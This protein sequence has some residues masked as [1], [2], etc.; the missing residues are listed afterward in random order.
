MKRLLFLVLFVN[1]IF[2]ALAASDDK[3]VDYEILF[4]KDK[5]Q[6]ILLVT[7]NSSIK[8]SAPLTMR[9]MKNVDAYKKF[10]RYLLKSDYDPKTRVADFKA[11]F[12]FICGKPRVSMIWEKEHLNW[13]FITGRFL[14][15]KGYIKVKKKNDGVNIY[16]YSHFKIHSKLI[17]R[18]IIREF[19][20]TI[21]ENSFSILKKNLEAM[22]SGKI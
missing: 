17:P 2:Q 13:E 8:A 22:E 12:M 16:F 19:T 18:W 9:L 15:S 11:C 10:S 4:G 14:G 7:G 6:D 5:E 1:L 20:A 3:A 21:T